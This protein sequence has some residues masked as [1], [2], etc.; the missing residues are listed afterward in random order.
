MAY[1]NDP[2]GIKNLKVK[3][4]EKSRQ[5]KKNLLLLEELTKELREIGGKLDQ[6]EEALN[7]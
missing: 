5:E 7:S 1:F 3:A 2:Y 4:M 6:L